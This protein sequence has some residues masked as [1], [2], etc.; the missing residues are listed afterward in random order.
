LE[1]VPETVNI[2]AKTGWAS[3]KVIDDRA[4]N[5]WRKARLLWSYTAAM[6]SELTLL[7]AELGATAKIAISA[8]LGCTEAIVPRIRIDAPARSRSYQKGCQDRGI[9]ASDKGQLGKEYSFD[10]K[11]REFQKKLSILR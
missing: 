4:M 5:A 3:S 1:E 6:L 8:G 11:I 9:G 7:S 2:A 10:F